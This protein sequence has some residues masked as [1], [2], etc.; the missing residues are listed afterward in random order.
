MELSR[1]DWMDRAE[2][3]DYLRGLG[4]APD[5]WGDVYVRFAAR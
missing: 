2:L 5:V 3:A 1:P 4:D